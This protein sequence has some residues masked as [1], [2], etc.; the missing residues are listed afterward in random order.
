MTAQSLVGSLL[1][2]HLDGEHAGDPILVAHNRVL[3][4]ESLCF[5]A[6]LSSHPVEIII[7]PQRIE[8]GEVTGTIGMARLILGAPPAI[9]Q[10]IEESE[11]FRALM[12]KSPDVLVL[13]DA[14]ATALFASQGIERVLG[15][16]PSEFVG[17]VGF[18]FVHPEH[19]SI[20]RE[21]MR[22]ILLEPGKSR[23]E[24]LRVRAKDNSWK[25]VEVTCTNLLDDPDIGAVVVNFRDI[26]DRKRIE[27]ERQVMVEIIHALNVTSNLDEFLAQMHKALK[28][29]VSAENCF[30]ALYD[31]ESAMVSFPFVV[32]RYDK[33][34]P[35]HKVGRTCSAYVL[36][37]GKPLLATKR[38]FLELAERGEIDIVGTP[39]AAWLGVPLRTTSA[40]LGVLV[41]QNYDDENAYSQRDLDLL[42]SVG[43]QIAMAIERKRAEQELRKREE[44]N[45]IIFNS[46]PGMIVFKDRECRLV[47][48]N[49]ATAE[50]FGLPAEK[51]R[52][53]LISELWPDLAGDSERED[54]EVMET[55]KPQ[56]GMITRW[57]AASGEEKII[58]T[59]RIPYRDHDGLIAGV[60]VLGTDITEQRK[61]RELLEKAR[62]QNELILQCAGEGICGVDLKGRCTMVNPAAAEL[63]GWLRDE[64]IGLEMHKVW[65]HSRLDGTSYPV[66]DCPVS[67]VFRDGTPRRVSDEVFWRKDGSCFPV[68]YVATPIHEGDEIVGAVVTFR[69]VTREHHARRVLQD[70]ESR[71]RLLVENASYAIFRTS[72]DGRFLDANH[73][74][75]KMLGYSSKDE[76]LSLNI[77]ESI[78]VNPEQRDPL[79]KETIAHGR[80]EGREVEWKRKDG[81]P[82]TVL[83]SA[84]MVSDAGGYYFEGIAENITERRVLETQ[85]RQAQKMEAVGRLAGGV[86]HDFNNLLMVIKGH[87]ELLLERTAP[88]HRDYRKVDQIKKAAE[89]ATSL[90][91]QL[92]AFSRMQVMQ[93]RVIDLNATVVEMG[94]MLPR[95]IGED[96]ELKILTK[97]DLGRVKADPGQIE[98]VILNLSVNARDAMPNGG[99]LV[100]ETAN[101]EL[102]EGYA[103]MHPPLMPGSFVMLAV[104]DTGTGMDAATQAHIFEPF[105]TTKEKGKGTGLG[106]A[107]VYG[108]VKQSGGY[109]WAYSEPGRGTSFKIYLPRASETIE[110]EREKKPQEEP[111]R[112]KG[113]ILVAEDE[114]EVREL[115]REFLEL[116]GYTVLEAKDGAEAVELAAKHLGEIDLLVTDMVMRGMSGRELS[117]RLTAMRAGLRVIYMSGYTEYAALR[118][119][120]AEPDRIMLQKP[121][122][123]AVLVHT[124]RK[125]LGEQAE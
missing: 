64:L 95:L 26:T 15:Y 72:S 92:L 66:E 62:Y 91:R 42:V 113:T 109:I 79:V 106:L 85:L 32:D 51:M 17:R 39:S 23:T 121:F 125:V 123:R 61:S 59:H 82:L 33:A 5:R 78:Y 75:A 100:I 43:A 7:A 97:P 27:S 68:E 89:R 84:R 55:G 81:S 16:S 21:L 25:Q 6:H 124:V 102:D 30:V 48:A 10:E 35:P 86:A 8:D 118:H 77:R 94:K 114:R 13:A 60:I 80:V 56:M 99:N 115:A 93:P 63:T 110:V 83:L 70:S 104:S 65:H 31:K 46:V 19:E 54:R 117:A 74:L 111:P 37:T 67:A 50:F 14:N 12:D 49:H 20:A 36:R 69:D 108:V 4:G 122:T 57:R 96:I 45:T 28:T 105:F 120:D 98:Q 44:E 73:A 76:L 88:E 112:G 47:R 3:A 11:R 18:S 107:T 58:R 2:E 52:G 1:Q 103:R 29:V 101:A 41:V 24:E 87:S 22:D 116:S 53:M 34:P 40:T 119:G 71:Y 90:T 9:K 38:A